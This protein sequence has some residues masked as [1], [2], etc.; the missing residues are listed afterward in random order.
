MEHSEYIYRIWDNV[1]GAWY[2]R[3]DIR[4]A[5]DAQWQLDYLETNG[6]DI[7]GLEIREQ[8]IVWKTYAAVSV[9][10]EEETIR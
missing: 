7:T 3:F 2:S 10:V 1:T 9:P 6:V 8:E 5:Q 4:S